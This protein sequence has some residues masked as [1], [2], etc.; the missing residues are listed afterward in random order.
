MKRN[1]TFGGVVWVGLVVASQSHVARLTTIEL[2]FL[3]GPLVVVPLGLEL[4]P[5]L[6]RAEEIGVV[7]GA[8]RWLQVPA[9][10]CAVG[11]FWSPPGITAAALALPWLGFGCV[12]GGVAVRNL[13]RGGLKSLN[14]ACLI[15][16]FL[17]LPVGCAWLVASRL[18]ISPMG[19]Q[20]PI[21]L[22]T[23]V[24]FH[25]AGFAAPLLALAVQ[26]GL[27]LRNSAPQSIFRIVAAGVLAGPG[28]LAAGFV[29]GPRVKLAAALVVA[30]SE[31]ALSIYFLAAIR[32]LRPRLAQTFVTASGVSV[33]FAM[34]LAAVW[35]IGEFPLQPFVHLDEM[36]RF[37]G[38]A[39]G[40]GFILCGLVGWT[41]AVSS[42]A[43]R[44][45]GT[46]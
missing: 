46:Q 11:A 25:F 26:S 2:L 15:A 40:I 35:A 13:I 1:A 41:L 36:A 19:F 12:M 43:R 44:A 5:R 33:L 6:V 27:Q 37:H 8:A 32:T 9:A 22:L 34:V 7:P 30:C 20:E 14:T 42:Q 10:L 23:A 39:N 28:L 38:T 17:Y 21:V 18:G 4:C 45:G 16:S 29:I 3:L 31:V 24:H